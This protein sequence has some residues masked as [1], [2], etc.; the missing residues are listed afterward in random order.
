MAVIVQADPHQ[1]L[2]RKIGYSIG[3]EDLVERVKK[4]V[5]LYVKDRAVTAGAFRDLVEHDEVFSRKNAV[6]HFANFYG[7]LNLVR[8]TAW[9]H[10]GGLGS[11]VKRTAIPK[12]ME[13]I[14][15]LDSLSI[16]RRLFA[17]D[18]AKYDTAL[19]VVLT[20]SIVE[21]DGDIFLN[22]LLSDFQPSEMKVRLETMVRTK[23]RLLRRVMRNAGLLSKIDQIVNIKNE[24][25]RGSSERHE[26]GPQGRYGRRTESLDSSRR[27]SQ[28]TRPTENA[29]VIP[30]DYLDKVSTTRGGW[31]RDL[32]FFQK[33]MKTERG[34]RLLETLEKGDNK[35]LIS[36]VENPATA[37]FWGYGSDLQRMRLEPSKIDASDCEAWDLLNAIAGAFCGNAPSSIAVAPE[38]DE[39]FSLLRRSYGLYKEGSSSK[40]LIRNSFPLY[41]AE[42][43]LAGWCVG[44]ARQ[45]P[46][47]DNILEGEY[48]KKVRRVQK[49]IIRG[50]A[51]ALFFTS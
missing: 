4:L 31:A 46:D 11:K 19:K 49:M 29:V 37:I 13:P 16:L 38:S 3:L 5:L 45:L 1:S 27:T 33:G 36:V 35:R 21:A 6:E 7:M 26:L 28:L 14:Y 10:S 23:R 47:L 43:V 50:T 44:E 17:S 42:P 12:A 9:N 8:V 18:D 48:T 24:S 40:G 22:G 34:V 25:D 20:Q 15:Q 41:V 39:I 2:I 32:G 30:T 51:G